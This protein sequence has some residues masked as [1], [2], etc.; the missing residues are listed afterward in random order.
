LK[1]FR[2]RGLCRNMLNKVEEVSIQ[3]GCCKLTLEVLSG[4]EPAQTAYRKFGFSTFQLDPG[5]GE[6]KFWEKTTNRLIG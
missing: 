6:A 5:A 4:N 3:K 2:G 1:E